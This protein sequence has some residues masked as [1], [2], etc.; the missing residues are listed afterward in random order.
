[1]LGPMEVVLLVTT[2]KTFEII[3]CRCY[4]IHY[5]MLLCY[6]D[7]TMQLQLIWLHP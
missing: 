5:V 2:F 3:L 1:M 4:M 6:V 7:M